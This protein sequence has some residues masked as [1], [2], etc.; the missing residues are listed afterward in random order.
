MKK[1]LN[2]EQALVKAA[3]LCRKVE[4]CEADVRTK[5]AEWNMS[6]ADIE[7][8]VSRLKEE[9]FLDEAR[10][11]SMAVRRG[12]QINKWG[13]VKIAYNLRIKKV[14]ESF[15]AKALAEINEK[16]YT[17]TLRD[18]LKTKDNGLKY[19]NK[20]EHRAKLFS[21]AMSRGFESEL[22]NEAVKE[23]EL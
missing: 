18:L 2:Y 12:L 8:I 14:D 6:E 9:K 16:E 1:Q 21:F 7:K 15:I 17:E 19:K 13:K 22:I 5:L 11:C 4:R 23:I 10:F 20:Y 3:A